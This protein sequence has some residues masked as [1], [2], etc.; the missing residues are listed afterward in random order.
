MTE[1][2]GDYDIN[3]RRPRERNSEYAGWI[4]GLPCVACMCEGKVVRGVHVSHVRAPS[5]AHGKRETGKAEKPSDQ[6]WTCPLCPPHHLNGGRKS[7]HH[8]PGGEEKFWTDKGINVFD[9]CLALSDAYPNTSAG[10]AVIARFAA[11]GRRS[12]T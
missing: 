12:R 11:E 6:P 3:Q 2:T 1:P 9:L 10:M 7:Q 4:A 8:Y 5:A